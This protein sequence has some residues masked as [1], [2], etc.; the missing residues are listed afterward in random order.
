MR[1]QGDYLV[2]CVFFTAKAQ[3]GGWDFSIF[4]ARA[5]RGKERRDCRVF[6][7]YTTQLLVSITI[8]V[9]S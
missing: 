5:Q 7:E 8:D 2:A 4:N 1:F 3:R 6:C 9:V